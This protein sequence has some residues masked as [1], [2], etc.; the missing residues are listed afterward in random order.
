MK[1]NLPVLERGVDNIRRFDIAPDELRRPA[2]RELFVQ[3]VADFIQFKTV[4]KDGVGLLK[5]AWLAEDGRVVGPARTKTAEKR[6]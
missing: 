3:N 4:G 6:G 5:R 2:L 1:V